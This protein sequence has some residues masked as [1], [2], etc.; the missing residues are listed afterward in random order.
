MNSNQK[1]HWLITAFD[2][3]GGREINHSKSVMDEMVKLSA[4]L[5]P[6]PE[7]AFAFHFRVL[8]VEYDTCIRPIE[9]ELARFEAM[10]IRLEGILSLGEGAEEF[11]IETQAN[12]LDD[13]PDFADNRGVV[14]VAQK[15]FA[16]LDEDDVIPMRFP[17][18]A[19]SRIRT[20]RNPGFFVCNHLCA[21]VER[22]L[23]SRPDAPWF[24]FIHVP[25]AGMGGIFTA[26]VCASIILNSFKKIV[27]KDS[28]ESTGPA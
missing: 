15:I 11:K 19:F 4:R 3:F 14:R 24:G 18:E 26:D 5:E 10:G 12:N 16:D 21:R 13:V 17:F 23:S 28:Q 8:P 9:E 22:A 25:R 7:G 2:P 27:K 1:R 6:T 20:S